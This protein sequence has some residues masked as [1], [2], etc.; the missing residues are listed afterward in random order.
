[1]P[2]RVMVGRVLVVLTAIVLLA[3]LVVKVNT[4]E[5]AGPRGVMVHRADASAGYT[6]YS[7]LEL[8]EALL[9]DNE[10]T[11]VHRWDTTTPPG[12]SEYLLANGDLLRAGDLEQDGPFAAGQGAGGR[13]EQ[14]DWDGDLVWRFDYADDEV[15][16]HHDV[17]P[18]PN[19]NVLI[20]AWERVSRAEA[21]AAGRDP[22]LLPHGELWPDTV[23]EYSPA[24]DEIVWKWRVWDHLVQDRDPTKPNFGDPVD[25]PGRIDVNFV[26]DGDVGVADW[27]H[28]N[29]VAYNSARDEVMISSRSFSEIWVVDHDTTTAEAAGADGDL[30]FR[31]GNT[32]AYGAG[33]RAD[34]QLF[35]QH[36]PVWIPDGEKGMEKILVFSNGLPEARPFST[37]EE[38]TPTYGATG[39]YVR[40][41]DGSFEASIERVHPK[42]GDDSLF[43][44][45]V[46]G[47]QRLPNGNTLI[48]YGNLGRMIEVA[49]DGTVVWD[50]E[51]P[52]Y[53][54]N[55]DTPA[56]TGAGFVIEP[57]W[58]FR[59]LRYPP[60]H[61]GLA[62]L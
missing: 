10:G 41:A 61:P 56:R 17:E 36:D 45:I 49:P 23:I 32:R 20:V 19:G 1:M 40:G 3:A 58:T 29:S 50:F 62:R 35:V 34:Q 39:A 15:M 4:D 42:P 55:E 48:V 18:M 6:L 14:L 21:L 52:W 12:L 57:W 51:N 53:E 25:R 47:A 26:L 31:Y 24:L 8:N 44:A 5:D 27:N 2:R 7:P 11:L 30:R 37:V 22:D 46:S 60:S 13:I 43:A 16:Q 33:T 59:G 54:I 28:L 9:V 38:I